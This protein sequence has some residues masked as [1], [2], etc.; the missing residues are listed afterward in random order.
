MAVACD[1]KGNL[2]GAAAQG[3]SLGRG[4]VFEL[5]PSPGGT[6]TETI[7]HNFAYDDTDGGIRMAGVVV[8]GN[9][10]YS[11]TEHGGAYAWGLRIDLP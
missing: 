4:L 9:Q 11:T 3:G 1:K 5:S 8:R 7:L 10:L 2:Y 6:W